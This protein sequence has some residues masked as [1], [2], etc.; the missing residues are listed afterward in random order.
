MLEN[1]TMRRIDDIKSLLSKKNGYTLIEVAIAMVVFAI[2]ALTVTQLLILSFQ[3]N[4]TGNEITQAVLLAEAKMEELKSVNDVAM[5]ASA[6]ESN[7]N[8]YGQPGGIYTRTANIA[9]PL[10]G[11]FSRQIEVTVQWIAKGR[12]RT[13][14]L[15]SFTH[16]NGI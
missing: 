14:R 11:D 1:S 3:N 15:T 13:V 8:Q 10:G 5:L 6:V 4:K 16:G 2:G 9:N 7:I 12:M